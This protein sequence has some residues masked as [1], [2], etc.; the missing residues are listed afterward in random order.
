MKKFTFLTV[1]LLA[2]LLIVSGCN[3]HDTASFV[4]KVNETDDQVYRYEIV[5]TGFFVAQNPFHPTGRLPDSY[6]FYAKQRHGTIEAKDLV[7][8]AYE[9]GRPIIAKD[10]DKLMKGHITLSTELA[11]IQIKQVNWGADGRVE[12]YTDFPLNGSYKIQK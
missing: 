7:F 12:S 8:S 5:L 3:Y 11:T 2:W 6:R 9:G 1:G 4:L 10:G